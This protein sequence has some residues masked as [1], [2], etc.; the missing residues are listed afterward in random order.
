[1]Y[2]DKLNAEEYLAILLTRLRHNERTI[3]YINEILKN[4]SIDYDKLVDICINQEIEPQI[5]AILN[6]SSI[7]MMM[8]ETLIKKLKFNHL[9]MMF[10]YNK[11]RNEVKR[12]NNYFNSQN[13]KFVILKG[14]SYTE[15]VYKRESS[16][17]FGDF[18]LLFK[19]EDLL[20]VHHLLKNIG[21]N[22]ELIVSHWSDNDLLNYAE[23]TP[24]VC[25][26]SNNFGYKIEL[27]ITTYYDTKLNLMD[28]YRRSV[29]TND[30][31][32]VTS[33]L[34]TFLVACVHTWRNFPFWNRSLCLGTNSL[35]NMLDVYESYKAA[36][37]KY[38]HEEI[39]VFVQRNRI[40]DIVSFIVYAA[41]RLLD[42]IDE[43]PS[44]D[45]DNQYVDLY[46]R[47]ADWCVGGNNYFMELRYLRKKYVY[48]EMENNLKYH[49]NQHKYDIK[50][51]IKP[52][53]DI[54]SYDYIIN[55]I[56]NFNSNN[57]W[58]YNIFKQNILHVPEFYIH[59]SLYWSFH[60][61][62]V[63]FSP[64]ENIIWP[65]NTSEIRFDYSYLTLLI[66]D[67]LAFTPVCTIIQVDQKRCSVYIRE[68]D[69]YWVNKPK[70]CEEYKYKIQDKNNVRHYSIEIPWSALGIREIYRT[71][72]LYIDILCQMRLGEREDWIEMSW[73]SGNCVEVG[74]FLENCSR[75]AVATIT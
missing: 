54:F 51:L 32:C 63:C 44:F 12:I 37:N 35:R 39:K 22:Q 69:K 67:Q 31:L 3:K 59:F 14:L 27:H 41:L 25:V 66:G 10:M 13:I 1:M 21:Y 20:I 60:S 6:H 2:S 34:D 30:G 74:S 49:L 7:E 72:E 18:D 70:L 36:L 45:S 52:D 75:L 73:I 17:Q 56:Y 40:S 38:S 57:P 33:L 50:I 71:K 64:S 55:P 65:C 46:K 28:V 24:H 8:P 42:V 9:L 47:I 19:K 68:N 5:Y 26:Y 16:R 48:Q 23:M 11:Y 4:E 58:P 29:Y 15:H 62:F 53:S 61:L 43:L